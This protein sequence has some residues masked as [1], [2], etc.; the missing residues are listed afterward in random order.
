MKRF[1]QAPDTI[2]IRT[3][4]NGMAHGTSVLINGEELRNVQRVVLDITATD[5]ATITIIQLENPMRLVGEGS[6]RHIAMIE[7]VFVGG[8][9][10]SA[11]PFAAWEVQS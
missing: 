5:I 3:P 10:V 4:R 8:V 11:N 9:Q 6:D 2:E 7:R 1:T